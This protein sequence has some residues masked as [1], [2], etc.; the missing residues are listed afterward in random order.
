MCCHVVCASWKM[1]GKNGAGSP[2]GRRLVPGP[3]AAVT[4][5]KCPPPSR[6]RRCC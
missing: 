4:A 2:G 5:R 3:A 6:A 1:L